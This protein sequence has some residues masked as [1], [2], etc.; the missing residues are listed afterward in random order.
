MGGKDGMGD[1]RTER[2]TDRQKGP[3][4][5]WEYLY[6]HAYRDFIL[7]N[8]ST[9]FKDAVVLD[10]GCGTGILSMFAAKAGARKV[11]AID[12]SEIAYKAERNV[13]ENGLEKVVKVVKGKLEEL[14]EGI[15]EEKVD[16][17]ISEWMG[18]F[19]LLV[20]VPSFIYKESPVERMIRS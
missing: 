18:Y 17:I 8:S 6:I 4:I 20:H 7:R 15:I 1:E 9:I 11:Y 13:K 16:V 19:L 2:Q 10:V 3:R 5:V 14:E 12:A